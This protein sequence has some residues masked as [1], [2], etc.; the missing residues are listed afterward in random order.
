M[1]DALSTPATLDG[2]AFSTGLV[3]IQETGNVNI[4]TNGIAKTQNKIRE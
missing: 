4:L 1:K 3:L 2:A